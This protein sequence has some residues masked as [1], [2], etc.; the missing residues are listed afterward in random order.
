MTR[1][2]YGA[3]LDGARRAE[4][5]AGDDD[6]R[7]ARYRAEKGS[8]AVI[9]G[10]GCTSA[11]SRISLPATEPLGATVAASRGGGKMKP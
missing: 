3:E 4:V 6:A 8:I 5:R 11:L 7:A 1:C 2:R 10:A 9:A